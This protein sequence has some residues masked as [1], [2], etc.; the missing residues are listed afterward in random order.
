MCSLFSWALV[1]TSFQNKILCMREREGGKAG[2]IPLFIAQ[3]PTLLVC[4]YSQL[5]AL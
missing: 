2:Q 1:L 4:Q 3:A 5:A